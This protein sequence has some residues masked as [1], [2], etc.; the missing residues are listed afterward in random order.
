[1]PPGTRS[2]SNASS[3]DRI[4]HLI[5]EHLPTVT[6]PFGKRIED[7]EKKSAS[8]PI[9]VSQQEAHRPNGMLPKKIAAL[10]MP[11]FPAVMAKEFRETYDTLAEEFTKD[12]LNLFIDLREKEIAQ[13]RSRS[14]R[15]HAKNS[16]RRSLMPQDSLMTSKP[17]GSPVR[18]LVI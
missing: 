5:E 3:N 14:S 2:A 16:K 4:Y 6:A 11:Q 9:V 15:I 17:R 13:L 8:R 1:M 12:I 10:R 18:S 7:I